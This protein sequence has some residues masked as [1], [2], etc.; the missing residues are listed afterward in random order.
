MLVFVYG[1]LTDPDVAGSVLDSFAYRGRATLAG[2]GRVDGTYPTL[3]PGG[4]TPGRLLETDEVALLDRYEGIANG[5]YV[6]VSVPVR[7]VGNSN[8]GAERAETYVGD[9]D[10]LGAPATWSGDGRLPD[11]VRAYVRENDVHLRPE[12]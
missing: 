5:L 7:G 8:A 4:E 6:R 1:T 9:P 2:L 3:S 11:R 10:R 12:I